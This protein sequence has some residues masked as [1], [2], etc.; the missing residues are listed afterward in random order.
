MTASPP[1]SSLAV[2]V[3]LCVPA[4]DAPGAKDPDRAAGEAIASALYARLCRSSTEPE[5]GLRIPVFVYGDG[6]PPP[7]LG[8]E[9]AERSVVVLIAS[10]AA[11]GGTEGQALAARVQQEIGEPHGR[12]R[13]RAVSPS[14]APTAVV[15]QVMR[16][17]LAHLLPRPARLAIAHASETGARH[18]T[19]LRRHVEGADELRG[20]L[21]CGEVDATAATAT[22]DAPAALVMIVSDDDV[23]ERWQNMPEPTLCPIVAA[24]ARSRERGGFLPWLHTDPAAA[25]SGDRVVAVL[26]VGGNAWYEDAV[27]LA[28]TAILS[29]L[30]FPLHQGDMRAAGLPDPERDL[31]PRLP[32]AQPA[33]A[34]AGDLTGLHVAISLGKADAEKVPG[35]GTLHVDDAAFALARHLIARGAVLAFGGDLKPGGFTL[36]LLSLLPYGSPPERRLRNGVA[37]PIWLNQPAAELAEH[38]LTRVFERYEAPADLDVSDAQKNAFFQPDTPER[39]WMWARSFTSMREALRATTHA[40]V[41]FCGRV[42]GS[43]GGVPGI[44]EEARLALRARQPLYLI[45]GY[46]GC[47]KALIDALLTGKSALFTK[48]RQTTGP[49][50]AD[51]SFLDRTGRAAT[52]DYDA[53]VAEIHRA[54]IAGLN[55]GLSEAENRVLFATEQLPV[56]IA[57]LLQG[58]RQVRRQGAC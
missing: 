50:M 33:P 35:I 46:G 20:L 27:D 28:L 43:S 55:N 1:R 18:A 47:A 16:D 12:H 25:V 5:P 7:S 37:W 32:G 17:L 6:A 52:A 56:M 3:F 24:D 36:K 38:G 11:G 51:Y 48:A 21:V 53:F 58:L 30:W 44:F 8:L 29:D 15:R 39:R 23:D 34:V 40:R 10:E 2:H 49:A 54:G 41:V 26:G 45:G 31:A 4:G 22:T 9:R 13:L 19:E 42:I 14:A 57:L